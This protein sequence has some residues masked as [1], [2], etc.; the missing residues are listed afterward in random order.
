MNVHEPVISKIR[1]F[2]SRIRACLAVEGLSYVALVVAGLACVSM[3]ID[4]IQ[5]LGFAGRLF[6][7]V[8]GLGLIG[9][10]LYRAVLSRL[11]RP[12]D[13]ER[14]ALTVEDCF[15]ELRDRLISSLQFTRI[16]ASGADARSQQSVAMM[17]AVTA[18][19]ADAVAP[20]RL[21]TTINHGRVVRAVLLAATVWAGLAALAAWQPNAAKIWF[22][23][24]VALQDVDWPQ[25]THLAVSYNKV[26]PRGDALTVM[27][28]ATGRLIPASVSIRYKFLDSGRKGR[29]RLGRVGGRG[30][31]RFEAKFK[32]VVEP[33]T[34]RVAGGDAETEWFDVTLVERPA[35]RTLKLQAVYPR[36]TNKPNAELDTSE[37]YLDL[38]AGT[39]LWVRIIPGKALRK[40]RLVIDDGVDSIEMMRAQDEAGEPWKTRAFWLSED[41]RRSLAADA[42]AGKCADELWI[43]SLAVARD[44]S[45][46]VRLID[47]GGL[48]DRSPTRFSIRTI[49]DKPPAV[50]LR[51]KGI[52]QMVVPDATIP[53]AIKAADD[54]GV[55]KLRLKHKLR[56]GDKAEAEDEDSIEFRLSY[57]GQEVAHEMRWA[58]ANAGAVTGSVLVFHAEAADYRDTG[59]ENVGRSEEISLRVVTPDELM[60]DLVRRQIN[61]RQDLVRVR[62]RQRDEV[63]IELDAAARAGGKLDA[64][65]KARLLAAEQTLR[66]SAEE[67][68]TIADVCD[69]VLQEMINNK[70]GDDAERSTLKDAIVAPTRRL[71]SRLVPG[72]ADGVRAATDAAGPAPGKP[73]AKLSAQNDRI[74]KEMDG[75]LSNMRKMET[76]RRMVEQVRKVREDQERLLEDI[77]K[78]YKK[79]IESILDGVK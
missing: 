6:S 23:R 2:R 49:A 39:T 68:K 22:L 5:R 64:A 44:S 7:L 56:M 4:Y 15:P 16:L 26:V 38:L 17:S 51:T 43:A 11:A 12:M 24:N 36:Y 8:V 53:L 66:R 48:D 54:Y 52:G 29:E 71:G 47:T 72:L 45:V 27:I 67:L 9:W 18:D 63:K 41:E 60:A 77:E 69:Q 32:N 78:A 35:V 28:E 42:A 57:G 59:P 58:V 31:H 34:F 40:A 74:L 50:T 55:R 30:R 1:A 76:Y 21:A 10:V 37:S 70:L 65:P 75:V 20:L 3:S 62:D 79:L 25:R 73:F 14:I 33:L 61:Q 46:A 13:D 19:A